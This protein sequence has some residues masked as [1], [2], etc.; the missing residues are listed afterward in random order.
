MVRK[1]IYIS[2][3]AFLLQTGSINAASTGS[4]ELKGSSSQGAVGECFEGFSRAMF[5]LNHGLDTAIFEPVA[6]GYRALP[7]P[8]RKATGNVTDNLRSLLTVSNN[9]LQG[10][11]HNAGNTA[12]R[13]AIN[14]TVGIL[15]IFDPAAAFGFEKKEKEDKKKSR[16]LNLMH[17]Y[18][19]TIVFV[20]TQLTMTKY[21]KLNSMENR[22]INFLL[23][24]QI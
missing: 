5:K 15:G 17:M 21:M 20:W 18:L 10:D 3:F 9:L 22:L 11:F 1:I 7:V 16:K 24:I 12:G 2:I 23:K 13:F 19:L 14:T 8:I 6:K 4:V